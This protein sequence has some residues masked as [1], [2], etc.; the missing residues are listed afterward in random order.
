MTSESSGVRIQ[1]MIT[2]MCAALLAYIVLLGRTA[3]LN[4]SGVLRNSSVSSPGQNDGVVF[5]LLVI[6]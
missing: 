5:R 6:R 2:L 1:L 4:I 3:V